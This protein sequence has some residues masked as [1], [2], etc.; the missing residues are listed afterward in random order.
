MIA[1]GESLFAVPVSD[2]IYKICRENKKG[3]HKK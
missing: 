3:M 1:D 2:M